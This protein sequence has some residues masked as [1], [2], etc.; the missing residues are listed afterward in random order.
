[1]TSEYERFRLPFLL[2]HGDEL[3]GREKNRGNPRDFY[4]LY[5]LTHPSKGTKR[6]RGVGGLPKGLLIMPHRF[7]NLPDDEGEKVNPPNQSE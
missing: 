3:I 4:L 1:M 7:T 6:L 5:S 2:T